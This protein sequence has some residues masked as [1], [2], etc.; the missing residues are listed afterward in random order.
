M[1]VAQAIQKHAA[2]PVAPA[3]VQQ[4]AVAAAPAP[5]AP[6]QPSL[7]AVIAQHYGLQPNDLNNTLM[8]ASRLG[9]ATMWLAAAAIVTSR[10]M[11]SFNK[12]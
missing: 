4:Q 12:K 2:Y 7:T 9:A 8:A 6:Q 3:P 1:Q 11:E 10:I 5:A